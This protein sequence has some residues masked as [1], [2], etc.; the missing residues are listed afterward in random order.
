[1]GLACFG[2]SLNLV[3]CGK[4]ANMACFFAAVGLFQAA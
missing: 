2:V 4:S 3:S 1:M